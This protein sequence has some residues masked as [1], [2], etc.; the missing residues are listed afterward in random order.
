MVNSIKTIINGIKFWVTDSIS[1]LN[2]NIRNEI[3]KNNN[4][5]RNSIKETTDLL[6]NRIQTLESKSDFNQVQGDWL[7]NDE[8]AVDYVKN[9]PGGYYELKNVNIF[10]IIYTMTSGSNRQNVTSPNQY[11]VTSYDSI[12]I[13]EDY[14]GAY[15]VLPKRY[16]PE[17]IL[18]EYSVGG[19]GNSSL[20]GYG[21]DTG[22]KY[23]IVYADR[24]TQV[25]CKPN[26]SIIGRTI[27]LKAYVE[28]NVVK[29]FD[30][31][32]MPIISERFVGCGK[33]ELIRDTSTL[34]G[35]YSKIFA[36]EDGTL[37][38][39]GKT[40]PGT[41]KN[42]QVPVFKDSIYTLQSFGKL[43]GGEESKNFFDYKLSENTTDVVFVLNSKTA[44]NMYVLEFCD[45][46]YNAI[47]DNTIRFDSANGLT[48]IHINRIVDGY[49]SYRIY[50]GEIIYGTAEENFIECKGLGIIRL[51]KT[52]G[53]NTKFTAEMYGN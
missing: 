8:T 28:K 12:T 48:V 20:C 26:D 7:Q 34:N 32:C 17:Y 15:H 39:S 38:C 5:L 51:S 49:V 18:D 21:E 25:Y 45:S 35:Q 46:E 6:D 13:Y 36:T 9:R 2:S 33:A 41:G 24:Q 40:L 50:N 23:F 22:E 53:S 4:N 11:I 27:T 31:S 52:N 14:S 10:T 43:A 30:S 37:Y 19:Y 44:K 3:E 16:I 47:Y 1:K 29:T 42:G